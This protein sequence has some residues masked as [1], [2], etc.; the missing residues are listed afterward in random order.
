MLLE[1]AHS[2]Q[3]HVE[4]QALLG[5]DLCDLELIPA[6]I[7]DQVDPL[8]VDDRGDLGERAQPP[9]LWDV[10]RSAAVDPADDPV[11]GDR[12]ELQLTGQCAG[13]LRR[14]RNRDPDFR[15]R[16]EPARDPGAE[17]EHQQRPERSGNQVPGR[18][19]V[20][21]R[22]DQGGDGQPGGRHQGASGEAGRRQQLGEPPTRIEHP[23]R[24]QDRE[25]DQEA[26][27]GTTGVRVHDRSGGQRG[28]Q[29]HADKLE[30]SLGAKPIQRRA[31]TGGSRESRCPS[32]RTSVTS[33]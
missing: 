21:R 16:L 4:L 5:D 32:P 7:D 14:A 8:A 1:L 24:E 20:E 27:P 3:P 28:R 26:V 10:V 11:A 31:A 25:H 33:D 17:R 2:A 9:H 13:D 29:A 30:Q 22:G 6:H 15:S 23:R 12:R 18:D 19:R